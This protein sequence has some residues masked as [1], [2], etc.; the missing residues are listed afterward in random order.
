LMWL[1]GFLWFRFLDSFFLFLLLFL[2]SLFCFFLLLCT[3]TR[4]QAMA[5]SSTATSRLII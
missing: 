4:T 5:M 2:R 3:F 1:L